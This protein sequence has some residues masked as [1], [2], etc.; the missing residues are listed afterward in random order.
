M[1][2]GLGAG[3]TTE[4]SRMV[5]WRWVIWAWELST[6][7]SILVLELGWETC[8]GSSNWLEQET[9]AETGWGWRIMLEQS[10][11]TGRQVRARSGQQLCVHQHLLPSSLQQSQR[12][13][14][15]TISLLPAI[16]MKPLADLLLLMVSTSGWHCWDRAPNPI[17]CLLH[18]PAVNA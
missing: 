9:V 5:E 16:F 14:N 15:P 6:S 3:A 8:S 13:L 10:T 18:Q 2:S 4:R 7:I 11:W 17:S 1:A 12:I